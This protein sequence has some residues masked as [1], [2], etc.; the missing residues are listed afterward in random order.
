MLDVGSQDVWGLFHSYAFDYTVWELW[1]AL[2]HGGRLVIPTRDTLRDSRL[3]VPYC[4][5]HGV[6]V[7]TQT[8]SAF[9]P[10]HAGRL[11]PRRPSLSLRHVVLGGEALEERRLG[12]WWQK[13]GDS[14][15]VT[16][17]YGPTE[18]TV[19]LHRGTCAS[20]TTPWTALDALL[21]THAFTCW[22]QTVSHCRS[23]CLASFT[24]GAHS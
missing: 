10:V 4:A 8:P 13:Y 18:A 7:L 22:M 11:C 14:V 24:L 9:V 2:R 5:T 12:P 17:F 3:L 21:Q 15:Q 20:R 23:A 16:N 19:W 1:G 6:T